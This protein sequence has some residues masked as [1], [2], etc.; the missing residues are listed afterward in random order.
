MGDITPRENM[1]WILAGADRGSGRFRP[2]EVV[3]RPGYTHEQ[4][5]RAKKIM[6]VVRSEPWPRGVWTLGC[7]FGKRQ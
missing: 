4:K 1:S 5:C 3:Q 7:D 6:Q 2:S